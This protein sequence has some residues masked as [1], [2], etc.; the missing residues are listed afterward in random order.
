M[1]DR[2]HH[3]KLWLFGLLAVPVLLVA[4]AAIPHPIVN[5]GA[6][7][8][9]WQVT[10]YWAFA[11]GTYRIPV[12]EDE[13]EPLPTQTPQPVSQPCHFHQGYAVRVGPLFFKTDRRVP[14]RPGEVCN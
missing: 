12:W 13:D 14:T 8:V 5:V 6:T 10:R 11:S 7:Q 4:L 2:S 3:R 9:T 1:R